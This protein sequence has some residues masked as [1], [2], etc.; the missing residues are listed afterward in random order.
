V[1][2]DAVGRYCFISSVSAYANDGAREF[3]EDVS[4]LDERQPAHE[5]FNLEDYGPRKVQC[6]HVVE[7]AFGPRAVLVRPGLIVGPYDATDRFTYWPRRLSEPGTVLAPNG[8]GYEF[9]VI[10][11]R[12]LGQFVL[13]TVTDGRSGPVNAV[14]PTQT[15]A[16]LIAACNPDADV[17]YA[18][19]EWLLERE[20]SPFVELPLW[21]PP[22]I[23]VTLLASSGRARSWGLQTRPLADTAADT[24]AWD[25]ER[26]LPVM[27][28][29]LTR[30]REASL[31]AQLQS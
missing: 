23:G 28:T 14:G 6:E 1:L 17:V 24:L 27:P 8:P 21:L 10:D 20:V 4:P 25:R 15:T 12:D 22:S 31:V 3:V 18:D 11:A 5:E 29:A 9:Q 30:E 19:H 2:R 16:D 26:G 7:A 13:R